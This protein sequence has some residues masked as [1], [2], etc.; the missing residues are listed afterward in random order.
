MRIVITGV[1]GFIGSSLAEYLLNLG[2]TVI[3][4]DNFVCGYYENISQ[5]ITS[6]N[7]FHFYNKSIDDNEI[8]NILQ[9]NDILIH[10]AA[11]S[12]LASNQSEPYFSY[13]NK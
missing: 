8:E 3:G 13:C 7:N 4:I 10:L 12:S 6:F 9:K 1:A 2:Y 11:I 5:L